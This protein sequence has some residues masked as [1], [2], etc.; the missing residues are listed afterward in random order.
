MTNQQT[1]GLVRAFFLLV[2]SASPVLGQQLAIEIGEGRF[3]EVTIP[4]PSLAGN[5]LGDPTEQ[6][7]SIYL[8]PSYH[9]S[10]NRRYP[11]VY[12]LH[13]FTGTNR[14]WMVNSQPES[15]EPS[16]GS[17]SR[18]YSHR[19][20]LDGSSLDAQIAEG[21]IRELIVVAPNTRNAYKS[22][23]TV[24][25]VVAGNWEDYLLKDVITYVDGNYRTLANARNRGLSGHSGGGYS[26][27][28]VGMRHPDVFSAVY[29]LSAANLGNI[30]PF[31]IDAMD[32]LDPQLERVFERL[33][34]LTS[35]QQ[36]PKVTLESPE[37]FWLNALLA[38]A[39]SFSPNPNRPPFYADYLFE[40]RDG[41]F[42]KNEAAFEQ[43]AAKTPIY[44]I[45]TNKQN[46]LSL[47]GLFLDYGQHE[48]PLLQ[49]SISRFSKA[50]A[51]RSIPHT[52]EIYAGGDHDNMI[53]E[54]LETRVFAFFSDRL[55][56]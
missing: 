33:V 40:K 2:L 54:R 46:L 4:A 3:I 53:R 1:L 38:G 8:P 48:N 7:V 32:E 49:T 41:K 20:Y 55:A 31:P 10:P 16:L 24:N 39:A 52:L 23:L 43:R 21:R 26:A 34:N 18:D 6:P 15:G 22:P 11:V 44:L 13:G 27:V 12:L 37:D 14:T 9:A 25:S 30:G 19:G 45:D 5:L 28:Y 29:A 35:L 51:E 42:I 47:R 17:T 36:L 56:F 50:L